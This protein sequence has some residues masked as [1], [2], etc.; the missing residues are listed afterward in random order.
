MSM[1]VSIQPVSF[2]LKE[3]CLRSTSLDN[4]MSTSGDVIQGYAHLPDQGLGWSPRGDLQHPAM[5]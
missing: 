1:V 4:A 5:Y 3:F 2:S